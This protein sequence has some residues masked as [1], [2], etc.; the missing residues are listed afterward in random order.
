QVGNAL[1]VQFRA[2]H[3]QTAGI[4]R[5]A[6]TNFGCAGHIVKVQPLAAVRRGHNALRAQ[7]RTERGVAQR[8]QCAVQLLFGVLMRRLYTPRGEYF[9]RVM[10]MTA[11]AMIVIVV[12]VMLVVM[13]AAGA[14]RAMVMMM[15][16]LVMVF[17]VVMVMILM[18]RLV[19][20]L[21]EHLLHQIAAALHRLKQL[22][23]GQFLPRRGHN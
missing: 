2:D 1:F 20:N 11:A 7:H 23:T 4:I 15:F 18:M 17:M 13:A 3:A 21:F 22:H 9:V 14:V 6:A 16:V 10:I 19:R 5:R 12:M 8:G